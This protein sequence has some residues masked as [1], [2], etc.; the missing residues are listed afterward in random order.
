MSE[1]EQPRFKDRCRSHRLVL[2]ST[3]ADCGPTPSG[4]P[5]ESGERDA[6]QRRCVLPESV[7]WTWMVFDRC[8]DVSVRGE[9]ISVSR[10]S[11]FSCLVT[12]VTRVRLDEELRLYH[13]ELYSCQRRP[14][15]QF[16]LCC[17]H[18]LHGLRASSWCFPGRRG[19][20]ERLMRSGGS[21]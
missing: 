1:P 9:L 12:M 6:S 15:V 16:R 18:F 13:S 11:Y 21:V 2:V 20:P 10:S 17:V 5:S 7:S 8:S 3:S 4:V 19:A 14:F